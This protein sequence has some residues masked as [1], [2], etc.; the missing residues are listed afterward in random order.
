MITETDGWPGIFEEAIV[1]IWNTPTAVPT[2]QI[3]V[4]HSSSQNVSQKVAATVVQNLNHLSLTFRSKY[5]GNIIQNIQ[6][7]ASYLSIMTLV[8]SRICPFVEIQTVFSQG[9]IDIP[10][11]KDFEKKLAECLERTAYVLSE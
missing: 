11:D 8:C 4:Q 1:A 3:A 9:V 2:A 10:I 6:L 5:V 7:A